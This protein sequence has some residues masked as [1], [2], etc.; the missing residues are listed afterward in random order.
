MEQVLAVVIKKTLTNE[1][2]NF[3]HWEHVL[4]TITK[5]EMVLQHLLAT[6]QQEAAATTFLYVVDIE[7]RKFVIYRLEG[8]NH[9]QFVTEFV[10]NRLDA[11]A[12]ILN[13]KHILYVTDIL[14]NR[15]HLYDLSHPLD[16]AWLGSFTSEHLNGPSQIVIVRDYLYVACQ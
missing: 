8:V 6:M 16:P 10:S 12:R 7:E 4:K 15:I 14:Q 2:A 1:Q 9:P 3:K 5:K 11:P 13:Y